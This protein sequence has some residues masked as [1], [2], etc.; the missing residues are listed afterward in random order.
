MENHSRAWVVLV[1]LALPLLLLI[2][3]EIYGLY[4]GPGGG[5]PTE[6]PRTDSWLV[7]REDTPDGDPIAF[8]NLSSEY[9]TVVEEAIEGSRSSLLTREQR[10]YFRDGRYIEYQQTVYDCFT[11]VP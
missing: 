2:A 7:C 10:E 8:E 1:L 11:A 3:P 5:T 4:S 9:Q 6:E